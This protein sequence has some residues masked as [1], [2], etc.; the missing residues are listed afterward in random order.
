[1]FEHL[2]E[3]QPDQHR[4]LHVPLKAERKGSPMFHR[5]TAK[6]LTRKSA[7]AL[8]ATAI[9]LTGIGVASSPASAINRVSCDRN[10]F[11]WLY[12]DATTCWANAGTASVR[13][14]NVGSVSSGNNAGYVSGSG[15]TTYFG[16][17]VSG[18]ITKRTIT[19]VHIN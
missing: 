3:N 9:A 6:S 10:D 2:D 5:S 8:A 12:S 1:M 7:V 14:D 4:S 16:K 15:I 13:L 19:T 18:G 17:W 11:L